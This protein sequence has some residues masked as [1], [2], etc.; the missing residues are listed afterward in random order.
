MKNIKSFVLLSIILTIGLS[1]KA[2][3]INFSVGTQ[4]QFSSFNIDG[5][6]VNTDFQPGAG[7]DLGVNVKLSDQWSINSGVGYAFHQTRNSIGNLS[8]MENTTDLAGESFRFNYRVSGYSE[9]QKFNSIS[10]PVNFQYETQGHTRFY[11]K[12]GASYNILNNVR[13]ESRASQLTTSGFFPRFNGTLTAPA[14]AGF[15]TFKNIDFDEQDFELSNSIN[16]TIEMGVKETLPNNAFIYFGAFL[17]YGLN[18]IK[19]TPAANGSLT[20]NST[21]PTRFVSNGSFD[22]QDVSGNNQIDEAKLYYAGVR[23]RYQFGK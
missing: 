2:Q 22:A 16:A 21:N 19:D 11:A 18:D 3:E 1:T 13:Q 9:T 4:F 14:F 8:G 6:S 15:G 20:F 5:S 23:I 7:I 17:E 10:I 12:L